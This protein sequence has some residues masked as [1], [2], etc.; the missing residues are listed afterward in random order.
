MLERARG[1]SGELVLQERDGTLEIVADGTFLMDTLD[2]RSERLLVDATLDAVAGQG[3]RVLIGGLGVGFSLLQA[4]GRPDVAAVEVVELEPAVVAWH[5][6]PLRRV[7]GGALEDPRVRV[8]VADLADR[9]RELAGAGPEASL[10]D[11]LCLDTDNGPDWLVRPANGVL[12]SADGLAL[13]HGLVAPYGAVGVWSAA[14]SPEFERRLRAAF[15][16]VQA[17]EVPV[18][19]GAPDVVWVVRP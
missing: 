4:L 10:V 17:H 6:G 9:L 13:A 19:R 5:E 16:S 1:I 3:K 2:G 18:V 14:P 11:A 7:T 8:V 12:W 15:G